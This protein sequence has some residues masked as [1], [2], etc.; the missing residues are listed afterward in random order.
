MTADAAIMQVAIVPWLRDHASDPFRLENGLEAQ[1]W[2]VDLRSCVVKGF[3]FDPESIKWWASQSEAAKRAVTT[4][5]PEDISGVVYKLLAYLRTC[6]KDH[7]LQSL[8]LWCQ[9][10]DFDI[11]ILRS[12][13]RRYDLDLDETVPHTSYRDCR[14]VII[15][16]SLLQ[17]NRI[18]LRD[19]ARASDI[20]VDGSPVPVTAPSEAEILADPRKAY[21]LYDPLPGKYA[22]NR[23]A[24]DA[25][26]DALRSS[27]NTWQALKWMNGLKY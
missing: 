5:V 7:D 13:C 3:D 2:N 27:W 1:L 26:Y 10:A 8:C 14:T 25:L 12:L 22:A 16:A 9:G 15:E 19:I 17:A 21:S 4:G 6:V 24:H 18:R 23:E 20:L 11:A